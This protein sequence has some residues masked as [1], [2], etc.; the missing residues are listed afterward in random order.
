MKGGVDRLFRSALVVTND[1]ADLARWMEWL[2]RAGFAVAACPGPT[3]RARCPRLEDRSCLLRETVNVA[4]VA[5]P[6]EGALDRTPAQ[7]ERRCTKVPDDGSTIF[8]DQFGIQATVG[9]LPTR[10]GRPTES[11]LLA[12]ASHL[13]GRQ[14]SPAEWPKIEACRP[15]A[16][17]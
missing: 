16:R 9:D 3:V 1:L 10:L 12:T 14:A 11:L 7:P 2:E 5:V 13:C 6:P 4:V 15:T 8:I 17:R